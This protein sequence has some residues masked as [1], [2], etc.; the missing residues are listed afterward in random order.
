MS[1]SRIQQ[2]FEEKLEK[3]KK[4]EDLGIKVH[5]YVFDKTDTVLSAKNKL[6]HTVKTAGRIV[7]LREHGKV[8]F[9]DI[10]DSTAKI[11]VM[12]RKGE[13]PDE[14]FKIFKLLDV[15]DFIGVIGEVIKTKTQEITILVKDFTVLSKSLRPIPSSWNKAQDKEVRF[16]KRY[17]DLLVN[18]NARHVLD[19]R[20]KVLKG[21]RT[22][23][24]NLGFI[25]VET[26]ILQPLYGGTNARPF[27]T[28]INALDVDFYLRIAPEL[29]LKRLII[30]GYEKIFEI[31][32]NFRNEGM[33]QTHQP[34][35]TMIE[36]Y[37]AYADYH[38]MMD[39]FEALLKSLAKSIYGE[40]KLVLNGKPIDIS[41]KWPRLTMVQAIKQFLNIDVENMSDNS[42]KEFLKQNDIDLGTD[43][44]RGIAIFSIFDHLVADKLQGPI[45]IIDYPRDVS[46]L[47]KVHRK[48]NNLV[49]RFECYIGGREIA[50]G[51]S[52]L[53]DPIEQ[54]SR[55]LNEQEKMRKGDEEAQPYDKD[56]IEA[57]EYGMPPLGGIGVGI[58]RLVMLLTD[59]WSIKETIAFPLLR[60]S[61]NSSMQQKIL[62]KNL[63]NK[64]KEQN[65]KNTKNIPL[66]SL[67]QS[68]SLLKQYIT[69]ESLLKHSFM[70]AHVMKAYAKVLGED[71]D[72][73]YQA[74]LLHDLDWE[75]YPDEHPLRAVNEILK[76]KYPQELINA[77]KA[78]AP[79]RTGYEPD[80][81]LE[82]YLFAVDELSGFLNAISL[83]RPNGFSDMKY[84]SFKKKFKDKSFAANVSREDIQKGVE[85]INKPLNEHVEFV[86]NALKDFEFPLS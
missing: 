64:N 7:S 13:I 15:G 47:A 83:V 40:E 45:W 16:R 86:I 66:P 61:K 31:A 74:G 22:F 53:V 38:V 23:L 48:D 17:L 44:V 18:E 55:F 12:V 19:T 60:P 2:T 70:V 57:M 4:L 54:K 49:E 50:D 11:Q 3:R 59:T 8:I 72:L 62:D 41:S 28:H 29:Y 5:P 32:R 69:D 36:W 35:F 78:H 63:K 34:E 52:E 10:K 37:E 24:W 80:T 75:K 67:E 81:L 76:D 26:P 51:W 27:I 21:I 25:E 46:P 77:I 65:M 42:I 71:Q 9:F 20:W 73:W 30:A 82:R 58:D 39:R 43:Y 79:T 68:I 14:K 1:I 6:S 84:K 85:L 33:D 56:F